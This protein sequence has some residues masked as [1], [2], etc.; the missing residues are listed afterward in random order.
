MAAIDGEEIAKTYRAQLRDQVKELAGK[1][2]TPTLAPILV[3][4]DPGAR[5]YFRTKRRLAKDLGLNFAGVEMETEASQAKVISKIEELSQDSD[6]HGLFLELPLPEHLDHEKL[7]YHIDPRKDI[8]CVNPTNLGKLIGAGIANRPFT[9]VR[10]DFSY[11]FPATPSAIMHIL[12]TLPVDLEGKQMVLLGGGSVG[13]PL[14]I[15]LLGETRSSVTVCKSRTGDVTAQ[16]KRADVLCVAVGI[17]DFVSAD[18][19]KEGAIVVDVGI[20]ETDSGITGDV[21]YQEV[22]NKASHITPVPGG[23]GPVT[24]TMIM[25]NTI[26]TARQ[27]ELTSNVTS[28]Q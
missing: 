9:E 10:D 22:K 26:Q 25:K 13:L 24:T 14:S 7:A 5:V 18:M 3:G 2:I 17:K 23:V 19:V 6:I 21:K 11:M 15:L 1:G 8:D 16:S 28:T 12:D 20:N 4:E 27:L